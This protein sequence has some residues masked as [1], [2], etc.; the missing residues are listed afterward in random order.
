MAE[1][2]LETVVCD[3]ADLCVTTHSLPKVVS[4]TI[5]A[6]VTQRSAGSR[7]QRRWVA[8]RSVDWCLLTLTVEPRVSN[9][10]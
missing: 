10:I 5:E 9:S 4:A 7:G 3:P 6:V 1:I 2:Y 8:T